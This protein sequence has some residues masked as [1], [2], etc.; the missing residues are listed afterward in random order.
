MEM[1]RY[2]TLAMY[3]TFQLCSLTSQIII[4]NCNPL[5]I[6]FYFYGSFKRAKNAN[7]VFCGWVN[8]FA[9]SALIN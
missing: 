6:T 3:C 2:R 7:H 9:F 8:C 1:M 4:I 5:L